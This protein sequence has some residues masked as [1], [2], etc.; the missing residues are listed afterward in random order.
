MN[1][2]LALTVAVLFGAGAYQVL[3]RDLFRAVTGIILISNAAVL[4]LI[5]AGLFR[6]DAPIYPLPTERVVSDPLVQALALTAVVI[7]FGVSVFALMLVYRTYTTH[8]SLDQEELRQA[9]KGQMQA[10]QEREHI[11]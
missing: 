10:I 3:K 2:L 9:E 7:N 11:I 6:G 8:E 4:A 5:A 1:L